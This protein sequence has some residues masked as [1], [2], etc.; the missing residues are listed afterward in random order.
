VQTYELSWDLAASPEALWPFVSN[1]EKMNRATGLAPVRFEIE[2]MGAVGLGTMTGNQKV[3]G[4]ALRWREHPYEWIEGS[5]HVVLRVFEKGVLRWYVADV[6]LERLPNGGTRLKNTIR[7]EPR[8][9]LARV[10]SKWEIG[11]KYR[12]RL[13]R[14]YRR[15]DAMLASGPRP[16]VD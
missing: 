10:L 2:S 7:L 9:T 14:V 3:A 1:T 11:M 12:R 8:G 16:D 5:R 6:Q 13:D 4:L 15:L